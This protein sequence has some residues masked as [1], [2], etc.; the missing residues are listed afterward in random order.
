MTII[1]KWAIFLALGLITIATAYVV[2]AARMR[3][4]MDKKATAMLEAQEKK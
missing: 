4:Q 3:M 2:M 1:P